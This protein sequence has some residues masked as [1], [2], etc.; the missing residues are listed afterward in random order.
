MNIKKIAASI[1]AVAV[2]VAA[3]PITGVLSEPIG[4][5]ANAAE[6]LTDGDYS[7][8][9]NE[10]GETVTITKY[11][12][13]DAEVDIPGTLGGKTVTTIDTCAFSTY[14]ACTSLESITIP[15]SVTTIRRLAILGCTSLETI[16]VGE[17]NANYSSING[18]LFN[19]DKSDLV[20]YP[21]GK[22]D[23]SYTI[24]DSVTK[25]GESAFDYCKLLTNVTIPDSVTRIHQQAF[26]RCA[27]LTSVTIPGSVTTITGN[28]FSNCTSL[29]SVTILD[30][31]TTI[32]LDA[33]N[34]CTSLT[35]VTIPD[36]VR[37]IANR[38][39]GGC[40]SLEDVYYG[41]RKS[42]WEKITVD[43]G[44]EY[45]LNATIHFA[46]EDVVEPEDLQ[47]GDV[48]VDGDLE[49]R[50]LEDGTL[51]VK[52]FASEDLKETVKKLIIP[53]DVKGKKVTSIGY[54]SFYRCSLTSVLSY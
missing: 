53:E 18:V 50:I 44:N 38:A 47:P 40:T 12:G 54:M 43:E 2:L 21:A 5:T 20:C 1:M 36:S 9:V 27:S 16:T 6:T 42:Q 51:E 7:Y 26:C 23:I 19:K 32:Y 29:T 17:K 28:T 15:D 49:Y 37:S 34:E 45:L 35:S 11:T 39:F 3:A 24:P 10:D 14:S 46:K 41:G 30:G 52:G 4:V 48:F 13:S 31:V 25:I 8:T 33:F 22:K